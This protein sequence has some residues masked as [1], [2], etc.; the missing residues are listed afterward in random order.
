MGYKNYAEVSVALLKIQ[1]E[2]AKLQDFVLE[3]INKSI[4][5]ALN[6]LAALER[7]LHSQ[8]PNAP[9]STASSGPRAGETTTPSEP[10]ESGADTKSTRSMRDDTEPTDGFSNAMLQMQ[11]DQ[12]LSH[13]TFGETP[14]EASAPGPAH[15]DACEALLD[16]ALTALE[17]N[18]HDSGH[19]NWPSVKCDLCQA[20]QRLREHRGSK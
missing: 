15:E 16:E 5:P 4:L 20:S 12:S 19:H 9:D 7:A 11:R 1:G 13:S 2:V 8:T 3:T 10:P 18:G 6:Q 17:N 14:A